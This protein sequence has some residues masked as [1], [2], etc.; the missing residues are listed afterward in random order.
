MA[1]PYNPNLS[2]KPNEKVHYVAF[3]AGLLNTS[4]HSSYSIFFEQPF[5]NV[6]SIGIES[7]VLTKPSVDCDYVSLKIKDI[8]N[9][10]SSGV[11]DN[12]TGKIKKLQTLD[13]AF[14]IFQFDPCC[15]TSSKQLFKNHDIQSNFKE[16]HTP[17]GKL[18]NLD[19]QWCVTNYT[20]MGQEPV[21]TNVSKNNDH[22]FI[23][24]IVTCS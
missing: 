22:S 7:A 21:F 12:T 13:E 20:T 15:E 3:D 14:A 16:L 24:K 10:T 2:F 17:I 5:R 8:T 4:N 11:I 9:I 18:D 6:V 19:L 1:Y 23:L